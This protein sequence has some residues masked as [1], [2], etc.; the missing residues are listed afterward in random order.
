MTKKLSLKIVIIGA[1]YI[2]TVLA[3]VL[4]EN[5]YK[6]TAIDTNKKI[7]ES[8]NDGLLIPEPG[9]NKLIKKILQMK[10]KSYDRNF[11]N[12]KCR[13]NSNYRGTPQNEDGSAN[14]TATR[15]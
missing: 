7:I 5:G 4:A 6:I 12:K 13:N 10:I 3:V 11:R 15:K 14:K 1:G 9:L 8:Y 2:G